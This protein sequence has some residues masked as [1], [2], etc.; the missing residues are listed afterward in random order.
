MLD[1]FFAGFTEGVKPRARMTLSEW[2][3]AHL[4]LPEE[5]SASPG[6]YR[7]G[8]AT[9][10]RGMMDAVTDPDNEAVI[11]VTSSQV[12]KTSILSAAQGYYAEAEPSPQLSVFPNQIIADAYVSETFDPTV[13]ESPTLRKIIDNYTYPGGYVAFVGANNPSQLAMRPIRVV[14]GDEVD[15][16]PVSSGKEGSPIKLA[17][18]RQTTYRNRISIFAS[19]PLIQDASAIVD[20]FKSSRQHYFH[21]VCDEC[22]TPQILKW[23]NVLFK[24]GQ[25]NEVVYA[26]EGCGVLWNEAKKRRLVRDAEKMGGGW[27]Y[28]EK[29]PFKCFASNETTLPGH[30][31]FWINELYSP[32]VSMAEM[33]LAWSEAEGKPQ[34]EQT[35]YNTRLGMPWAGDVSSFADPEGLKQRREKY[36]PMV[37]PRGAALVVHGVDVQ[38]DR[39]EVLPVAFGLKDECWLLQPVVI[40]LDPSTEA[41]WDQLT[42]VLLRVYEHP[43]GRAKLRAEAVAVDSGGHFTRRVYAYS[44]KHMR[45]GRRWHAIK[46]VSGEG[47]SLWQLSKEKFKVDVKLYLVGVDDAKTMIYTRYGIKKPG[48]GYIHLHEGITDA[49]VD[50]LT[51]ERAEVEYKDGFPKRTWTKPRQRRNEMLDM[52]VYAFAARESLNVDIASRLQMLNAPDSVPKRLDAEEVGRLYR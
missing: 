40:P 8:D 21:V 20:M 38:D 4:V 33:A 16:W 43:S 3:E 50:Q 39:I 5:R 46:G 48:P 35:F 52:L 51:A 13:R 15:R 17:Q 27:Q 49:Q 31:G 25:E 9:Y 42:E 7:V 36:D 44:S 11:F 32:W 28:V 41:A 10:Q 47:K 19:T 22:E 1:P 12:G 37:L 30:V 6:P 29:S 24:K 2:A 26:C 34:D 23:E 45:V 14:T 18:K